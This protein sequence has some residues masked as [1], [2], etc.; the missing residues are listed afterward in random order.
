MI[1]K[2]YD[3]LYL[4]YG[5]Q[6]W[7]PLIELH[8]NT[9]VNPTKS[10]SI[11]GYHPGNYSYPKN[12]VQQWEIIL[13][14]VLTQNVSWVNVERALLNLKELKAINPVQLLEL[15][16]NMLKEA[17]K[18]AGYFNQKYKTLREFAIFFLALTQKPNR[19]E[20]LDLWGIGPETADCILLYAFQVPT[21]VVDTYTKRIFN[22]LK[23]ISEKETYDE[24]KSLFED[25]LKPNIIIYQEYHALLVEHAK[26]YYAKKG[27]YQNCPLY[28]KFG[29][30]KEND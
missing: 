17:I 7:F 4:K 24:I 18:P 22:N 30:I 12:K 11:N 1:K 10:G 16:E 25:N 9:G 8:N 3:F 14:C 21:F 5:P 6:G 2:I 29:K 20:L 26:R 23:L 19:K 27:N 15:D 28:K 13:G